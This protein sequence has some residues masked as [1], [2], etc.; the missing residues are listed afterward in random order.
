MDENEGD[1]IGAFGDN[2]G[3][4]NNDKITKF[5]IHRNFDK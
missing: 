3:E 2:D 1:G 4:D 5:Y